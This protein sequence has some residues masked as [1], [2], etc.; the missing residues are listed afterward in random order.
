MILSLTFARS[1]G[2]VEI[3][4]FVLGFQHFPQ[5]LANVNEWKIM[6]DPSSKEHPQHMFSWRS[7]KYYLSII[8]RYVPAVLS[9]AL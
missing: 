9:V 6:F 2:K 1:L 5:D 8:L 7:V 4:G 3:S